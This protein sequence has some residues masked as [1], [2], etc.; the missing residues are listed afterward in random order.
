MG[1]SSQNKTN[2]LLATQQRKSESRYTP[3]LDKTNTRGDAAYDDTQGR[4]KGLSDRFS[5]LADTGGFDPHSFDA[6]RATFG[7]GG[8]GGSS[9]ANELS[10][11][12]GIDESKFSSALAGYD[13]FAHGGGLDIEGM[14]ARGNS[15]VPAFYKNL[16]NHL[17][18]RKLV[19]PY[20]PTFDAESRALARQK[21]QETQKAIRDTELDIGD[22]V[23]ANKQ[24]GIKGLGDLN[25]AI[26]AMK[27]QG[28]I[29]GGSQQIS[30]AGL[31]ESAAGRR[32]TGEMNI[33]QMLQDGKL[34]GLGGLE[35]LFQTQNANSNGFA[36]QYQGGLEGLDQSQLGSIANR[37]NTVPW[38]QRVLGAA[39]G[40]ASAYFGARN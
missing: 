25:S 10:D 6:L 34:K 19:N 3:Y 8:G 4:L 11:T 24:F 40:P 29:A 31:A 27:Q 30:N 18:Q 35:G 5:N 2:N 21:G 16:E 17:E 28:K 38:W 12:G 15:A 23:S 20:A 22:R 36:A 33:L 9:V 26:Q 7:G 32:Q 39:S 37:Q 1:N 13:E 14:R